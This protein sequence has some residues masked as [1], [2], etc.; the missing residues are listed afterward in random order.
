MKIKKRLI[1]K[2]A[3]AKKWDVMIDAWPDKAMTVEPTFD[4]ITLSA[5]ER[6]KESMHER[7]SLSARLHQMVTAYWSRAKVFENK[8]NEVVDILTKL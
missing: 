3:T 1:K 5:D 7:D 8:K 4:K 2:D 6:T